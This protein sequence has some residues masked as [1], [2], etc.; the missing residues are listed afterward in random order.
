[1]T[2]KE[3]AP[4]VVFEMKLGSG[5][6]LQI[7]LPNPPSKEAASH[8]EYI[9]GTVRV[10]RED[11]ETVLAADR[12]ASLSCIEEWLNPDS[13][14]GVISAIGDLKDA[15]TFYPDDGSGGVGIADMIARR[16]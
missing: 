13:D 10:Q 3:E 16:E 4:R 11:F 1:M 2:E 12:T 5:M 15:L 14:H 7:R 8:L 9:I 6:L